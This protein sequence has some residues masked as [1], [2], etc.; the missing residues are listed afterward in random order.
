MKQ[1]KVE[2]RCLLVEDC[3]HTGDELCNIG[4][5]HS[6]ISETVSSNMH[7]FQTT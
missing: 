1:T 3:Q 7:C 4:D 6:I 2:C 5:T